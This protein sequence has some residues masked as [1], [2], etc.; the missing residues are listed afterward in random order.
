MTCN[1]EDQ[2]TWKLIKKPVYLGEDGQCFVTYSSF[3]IFPGYL[4]SLAKTC[5]PSAFSSDMQAHT[6]VS[7]CNLYLRRKAPGRSGIP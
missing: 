1:R 4:S 5:I 7:H 3:Y 6:A 2:D